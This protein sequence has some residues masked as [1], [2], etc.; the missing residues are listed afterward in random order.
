MQIN[1]KVTYMSKII[2]GNWVKID[3]KIMGDSNCEII[4]N[5]IEN[6]LEKVG[7]REEGWITLFKEKLTN[8]FWERIYPDSHMHGGGPPQLELLS[9]NE[10]MDKYGRQF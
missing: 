1:F 2:K 4:D 8:K 9:K 7:D 10:V 3:G 5:M 6:D